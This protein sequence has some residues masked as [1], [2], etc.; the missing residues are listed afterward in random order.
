PGG[1]RPVVHVSRPSQMLK[2]RAERTID[3][4][5]PSARR[6]KKG[7]HRTAVRE[8]AADPSLDDL[9]EQPR[10]PMDGQV[11]GDTRILRPNLGK[12]GRD[13]VRVGEPGAA[14]DLPG[15]LQIHLYTEVRQQYG[16]VRTTSIGQ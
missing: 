11:V 2:V 4:L 10:V 9:L 8:R 3:G 7:S 6:D 5:W 13:G 14:V 12:N 1:V 16:V 15:C